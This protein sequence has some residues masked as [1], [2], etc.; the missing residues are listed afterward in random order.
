MPIRTDAEI[1]AA[2]DAEE[3]LAIDS[4]SGVLQQERTDALARYRGLGYAGDD[5]L[6]AQGRSIVVDRSVLDT[7]EWIM[8]S[9]VRIFLG[10]DEI[11]HFDAIGP[12]DEEAAKAE[13]DACNWYLTAKNDTF[14]HINSTLRDAL[15]LKTAYIA[16]QWRAD[17][18]VVT[19]TYIGK[20]DEEIALLM[21]DP[22]IKIIEHSEYPDPYYP[23][24]P[25]GPPPSP[26]A[27][28]PIAQPGG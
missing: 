11:G 27:P 22:C 9:L 24:P 4:Q 16:G 1:L 23:A 7:I 18:T 14:S 19:E 3:A 25:P 5:I 20:A 15:L 28:G 21:D 13:T 10:G 12:E 17:K 2:I 6:G 8:P 26:P